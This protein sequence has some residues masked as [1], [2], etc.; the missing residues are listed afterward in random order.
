[1][2]RLCRAILFSYQKTPHQNIVPLHATTNIH[3]YLDSLSVPIL[4]HSGTPSHYNDPR[5]TFA[6]KAA[7]KLFGYKREEFVGLKSKYSAKPDDRKLR[8]E[9]MVQAE[10][11]GYIMGYNGIRVKKSGQLFRISDAFIWNVL[12]ND[13]IIGQ[14]AMLPK[15]E[16]V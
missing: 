16:N 6:N 14:A 2:E 4:A 5:F 15:Y 9:M 12:E 10:M 7:L 1:M 11:N 13:Q 3:E 8:E